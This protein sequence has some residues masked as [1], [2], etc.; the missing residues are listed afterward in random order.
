MINLDV[1][2]EM[3]VDTVKEVSGLNAERTRSATATEND[4]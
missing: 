2:D 4:R 3:V 1:K